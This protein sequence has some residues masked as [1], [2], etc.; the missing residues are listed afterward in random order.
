MVFVSKASEQEY[1]IHLPWMMY[2]IILDTHNWPSQV[3]LF[4]LRKS[5]ASL[6]DYIYEIPLPNI[7][8]D[9]RFCLPDQSSF[10]D[11]SNISLA[12]G[13][14][15]AYEAVWSS[16]FNTDLYDKISN[17]FRS[18]YP[19][20]IFDLIG[21]QRNRVSAANVLTAWS[22]L[23]AATVESMEFYQSQYRTVNDWI[24]AKSDME[25]QAMS[26]PM[27]MQVLTQVA[28]ETSEGHTPEPVEKPSAPDA[29]QALPAAEEEPPFILPEEVPFVDALDV[30]DNDEEDFADD[31]FWH[32]D[33]DYDEDND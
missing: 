25:N 29:V 13:I 28:R 22:R 21:N 23:D 1:S 14:N 26:G 8:S 19:T 4:A 30:D 6:N 15:T 32:E 16:N 24:A 31:D 9:D 3:F 17:A 2:G 27:F 33:E 12:Q 7:Y 10:S 5:I 11:F 18:G 20:P